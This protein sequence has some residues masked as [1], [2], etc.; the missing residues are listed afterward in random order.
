MRA[1]IGAA[2]VVAALA[3]TPAVAQQHEPWRFQLTPYVWMLGMESQVKPQRNLP[4]V[5]VDK[6][7]SDILKNLDGAVFLTGSARQG[8]FVLLADA[9]WAQITERARRTLVPGVDLSGKLR[10]RQTQVMLAAGYTVIDQPDVALEVEGRLLQF[11]RSVTTTESWL[12]PIFG[13][14]VRIDLAPNWSIIG[15]GDF[16]G[17]GVGSRFT[18]QAVGTINYQLSDA[19]FVSAGYRHSSVDYRRGGKRLKFDMSGPLVGLTWRF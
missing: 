12:D 9:S 18:W 11:E 3:V 8:R 14:R 6:S 15:Y 16:G 17:F 5:H 10:T 2:A 7:F 1:R 4:T 19:F 13:A